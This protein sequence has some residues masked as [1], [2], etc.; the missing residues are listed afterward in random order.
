M[1]ATRWNA[2][3]KPCRFNPATTSATLP[4]LPTRCR[5]PHWNFQCC[6]CCCCCCP[7][8]ALVFAAAMPR[9]RCCGCCVFRL[10]LL[11]SWL[12]PALQ[13]VGSPPGPHGDTC[14]CGQAPHALH[15]GQSRA[16]CIPGLDLLRAVL[17]CPLPLS[18]TPS[19]PAMHF[20]CFCPCLP[21]P[22]PCSLELVPAC[23]PG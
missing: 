8:L 13:M 12:P 6:C 11:P 14:V 16:P 22:C 21:C 10:L 7:C 20:P 18:T 23:A 15:H 1:S 9:P 4:E 5:V 3:D 2:S 19:P 17:T